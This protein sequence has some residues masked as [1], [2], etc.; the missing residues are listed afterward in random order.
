MYHKSGHVLQP[1][2]TT[3]TQPQTRNNQQP[4]TNS[5]GG[6]AHHAPGMR[7]FE[8]HARGRLCLPCARLRAFD[9]RTCG[10]A[11]LPCARHEMV[12]VSDIGVGGC[13][14]HVPG[15]RAFKRHARGRVLTKCQSWVQVMRNVRKG[16]HRGPNAELQFWA[17][18]ATSKVTRL[19]GAAEQ[20]H[21]N[22]NNNN[23]NNND[24]SNSSRSNDNNNSKSSSG[25]NDNDD[26]RNNHHKKKKKK[27]S[28]PTA[29]E[30]QQCQ[31]RL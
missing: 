18:S 7:A 8:R 13:A 16:R 28:K 23:N 17:K 1:W 2:E 25:D 4:T 12:H 10:R 15:M 27:N 29:A 11:C 9:R 30:R 21:A 20:P 31:Q 14:H 26:N 3:N 5:V 6:C 22:N 24:N 19:L